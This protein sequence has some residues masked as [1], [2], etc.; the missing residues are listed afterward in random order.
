MRIIVAPVIAGILS[1][2]LSVSC[3]DRADAQTRIGVRTGVNIAS[4]SVSDAPPYS[5]WDD[6]HLSSY[7]GPA[8]GGIVQVDL[9]GPLFLRFEP[10]YIQKG[11][12]LNFEYTTYDIVYSFERPLKLEFIELP[13][14]AGLRMGSGPLSP[15]VFVGPNIGYMITKGYSKTDFAVEVGIGAGYSISDVAS[16]IVDVRYSAGLNDLYNQEGDAKLSSRGIQP[17]IGF[18][19]L[20]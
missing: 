20:P 9:G 2:T 1:V 8:A 10:M 15:Y 18:L 12:K 6:S 19:F 4:F 14:N 11:A 3:S 13:V 5:Q 17:M 7:V 16:I